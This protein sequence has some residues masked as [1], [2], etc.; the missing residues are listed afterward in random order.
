MSDRSLESKQSL[1]ELRLLSVA[2]L[3]YGRHYPT[4]VCPSL[5][6]RF[7]PGCQITKDRLRAVLGNQ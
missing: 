7:K 5:I 4:Y 1:G 6:L 3:I 2:V